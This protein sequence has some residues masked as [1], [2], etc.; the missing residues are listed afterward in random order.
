M[1]QI[2]YSA[3]PSAGQGIIADLSLSNADWTA[4][5]L[6]CCFPFAALGIFCLFPCLPSYYLSP[7][8]LT[9][10]A[11]CLFSAHLSFHCHFPLPT[12]SVAFTCLATLPPPRPLDEDP[13]S[14]PASQ[15]HDLGLAK[16]QGG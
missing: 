3:V 9:V 14:H 1:E 16:L 15:T 4:G 7:S 10:L 12:A 8:P 11:S 13:G 2:S 6:S 5:C